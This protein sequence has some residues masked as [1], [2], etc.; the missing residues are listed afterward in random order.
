VPRLAAAAAATAATSRPSHVQRENGLLRGAHVADACSTS[1]SRST[2]TVHTL[3]RRRLVSS[4]LAATAP[5]LSV[6]TAPGTLASD[7]GST[8]EDAF[9]NEF[10][11]GASGTGTSTSAT[12]A[13]VGDEWTPPD[14]AMVPTTFEA[15]VDPGRAHTRTL[16]LL[17]P[18]QCYH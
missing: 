12:T 14:P 8:T 4:R 1:R 11:S 10:L 18:S 2:A 6:G 3:R 7:A 13:S 17:N 15:R 9:S 16:L 5:D